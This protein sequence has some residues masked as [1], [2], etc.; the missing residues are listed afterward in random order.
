MALSPNLDKTL[1]PKL[2]PGK[3]REMH[4][5]KTGESPRSWELTSLLLPVPYTFPDDPS[6]LPVSL[7]GAGVHHEWESR[8]PHTYLL[9]Y[10]TSRSVSSIS[11]PSMSLGRNTSSRKT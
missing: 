6:W 4:V 5:N 11:T 8:Q 7:P 9:K 1:T 2:N 10:S 3:N